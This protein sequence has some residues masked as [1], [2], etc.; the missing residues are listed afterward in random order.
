MTTKK[1]V[2]GRMDKTVYFSTFLL[3]LFYLVKLAHAETPTPTALERC[4][5]INCAESTIQPVAALQVYGT[6][7]A[8][9]P[10][11]IILRQN[12]SQILF[13]V[14]ADGELCFKPLALS[15]EMKK[16]MERYKTGLTKGSP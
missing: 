1:I 7:H 10:N 9:H 14:K 16:A 2:G 12:S 3:L 4:R 8:T 13:E 5:A 15:E 6:E 11:E